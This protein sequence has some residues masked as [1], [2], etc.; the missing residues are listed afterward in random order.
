MP[1][2]SQALFEINTF[3]R[4]G[5]EQRDRIVEIL[6][7]ETYEPGELDEAEVQS[8]VDAAIT[9]HERG[10]SA[11]PIRTDC[12]RLD[13]VFSALTKKGIVAIQYAGYTQSDGYEDI[14]EAYHGRIDKDE[15]VGYCFYHGQDLARAVN[16]DGLY[17]A[18]GPIDPKQEETEG[19]RVGEMIANELRNA[20]FDVRWNGGVDQ[21]IFVPEI[22]WKRR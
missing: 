4:G 13:A 6:T 8:A 5:F 20:G 22:D 2:D 9:L 12:E 16:G 11:W 15:V 14:S 19:P 21:R 3:V 1:L 7:E 17:L 10:K 18:F